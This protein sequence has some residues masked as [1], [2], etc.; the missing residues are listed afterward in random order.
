VG[1]RVL[2]APR[3]RPT[4]RNPVRPP[5]HR[6]IGQLR[7]G[8]AAVHRARPGRGRQ[9]NLLDRFERVFSVSEVGAY[10][11]DG[12]PRTTTSSRS[13]RLPRTTRHSSRLP[14][15]QPSTQNETAWVASATPF[16]GSRTSGRYEPL[17]EV[18]F[19]RGPTKG[20]P[21]RAVR[22]EEPGYPRRLGDP[23]SSLRAGARFDLADKAAHLILVCD[24]RARLDPRDRLADVVS[25][26][27]NASAG[28][29][30]LMPI[31]S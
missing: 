21:G 14:L 3:V 26:S 27:S 19:D 20:G 25:R 11:P 6:A 30:G 17:L 23:A 8:H 29:S 10:T 15:F 4:V 13:S 12:R 7:A 31:S 1:G 5:R 16:S 24:E 22:E 9:A 18:V 28:H 2:P